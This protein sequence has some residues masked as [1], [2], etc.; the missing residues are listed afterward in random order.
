MPLATLDSHGTHL[1]YEDSGV[2][3][4]A[5]TTYKTLVL[6]H[7]TLFNNAIFRPALPFASENNI[8][9]ITVNQR[10]HRQ[11]SPYTK[12]ELALLTSPEKDKQDAF[13]KTRVRDLANLLTFLIEKENLIPTSSDNQSGGLSVAF[14]S[15]ANSWM[16]SFMTY[17]DEVITDARQK[18]TLARYIRAFIMYD[19]PGIACGVPP[20]PPQKDLVIAYETFSPWVSAYHNHHPALLEYLESP[21]LDKF[22]TEEEVCD[23]LGWVGAPDRAPTSDRIPPKLLEEIMEPIEGFYNSQVPLFIINPELL[24]SYAQRALRDGAFPNARLEVIIC[25]R[26][27]GNILHTGWKLRRSLLEDSLVKKVQNPRKTSFHV[28]RGFNHVPHW[29]DPEE[30]TKLMA[31]VA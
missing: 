19:A 5:S 13:Y 25:G 2:P 27:I 26:T 8:R 17:A 28:W 14:W 30:F 22:T 31:S 24:E 3:T 21:T 12:E 23:A 9:I 29:D 1:Y 4:N 16:T 7:G 6:I 10:D 18:D 15:S 11:S 20:P